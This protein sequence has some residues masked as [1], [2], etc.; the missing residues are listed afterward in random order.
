MQ[1]IDVAMDGHKWETTF[2]SFPCILSTQ[3][4]TKDLVQQQHMVLSSSG[5]AN[6]VA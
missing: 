5:R 4:S 3:V 1:E 6:L 2:W